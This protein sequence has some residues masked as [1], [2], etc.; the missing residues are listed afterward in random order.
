MNETTEAMAAEIQKA[1]AALEAAYAIHCE[2][3]RLP[4]ESIELKDL[5]KNLRSVAAALG[6]A[7]YKQAKEIY[8]GFTAGGHARGLANQ[9]WIKRG[10]SRQ[11]ARAEP[12]SETKRNS[13]QINGRKRRAGVGFWEPRESEVYKTAKSDGWHWA[14]AQI[15][16]DEIQRGLWTPYHTPPA[17]LQLI[18]HKVSVR[19][20]RE[21]AIL[22]QRE[23]YESVRRQMPRRWQPRSYYHK[24]PRA[25]KARLKFIKKR[26]RTE[27]KAGQE[28]LIRVEHGPALPPID[29]GPFSKLDDIDNVIVVG[30][31]LHEAEVY[32]CAAGA[33]A[34]SLL[35]LPA[36]RPRSRHSVGEIEE[37]Q[38]MCLKYGG[39]SIE[40][41]TYA[42]QVWKRRPPASLLAAMEKTFGS[43]DRLVVAL[44]MRL[45]HVKLK[46]A[47]VPIE[48]VTGKDVI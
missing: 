9:R 37:Y 14:Q 18:L 39:N 33:K 32:F 19:I 17:L 20:E 1:A 28:F 7:D 45:P 31:I 6:A 3:S 29:L 8:D 27:I 46:R 5:A 48:E 44:T 41:A 40:A 25:L 26:L 35:D 13:A 16:L 30:E 24:T 43:D 10:A 22:L 36:F 15:L 4:N 38:R 2:Q 23:K 42:W 47:V 12:A 34:W 11:D 21:A